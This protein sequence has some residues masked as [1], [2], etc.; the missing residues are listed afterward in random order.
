MSSLDRTTPSIGFLLKRAQHMF[1]TSVDDALRPFELTAPQFAVLSAVEASA[2]ISNA[3]LAR[4][5]FVTPQTMQGILAGL[6][7]TGLLERSPHPQHGRIL[8]S[9][10]TDK[11]VRVIREA[12]TIVQAI[13]H[14]LAEAVGP[15]LLP[16]FSEALSRC[17]DALAEP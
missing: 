2:G 1:R 6:E 16:A 4:L 9:T 17:A 12:R 13:E 11:G 3:E 15:A 5:A 10:L 14:R 7:R 8:R